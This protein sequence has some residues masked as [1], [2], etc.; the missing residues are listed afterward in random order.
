MLW[1]IN[2]PYANYKR[3]AKS[4]SMPDRTDILV[5]C[6]CVRKQENAFKKRILHVLW[7][8]WKLYPEFSMLTHLFLNFVT[9]VF[10]PDCGQLNFTTTSGVIA[11]PGYPNTEYPNDLDCTWQI[12]APSG[13]HVCTCI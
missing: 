2:A 6:I 5:T 9:A 1:D 3:N 11:S 8:T 7:G 4:F 12:Y 13:T 10:V